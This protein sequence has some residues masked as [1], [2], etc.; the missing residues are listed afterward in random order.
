[1]QSRGFLKRRLWVIPITPDYPPVFLTVGDADP[2]ETR[3]LEWLSI[4]ESE[5]FL[6]NLVAA[7][8]GGEGVALRRNGRSSDTTMST[9]SSSRP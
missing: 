3:S 1:M 7:D 4:L 9:P 2:L 6:R 8:A 5:L